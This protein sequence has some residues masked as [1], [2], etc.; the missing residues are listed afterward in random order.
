MYDVEGKKKLYRLRYY[1]M[2]K[3][4]NNFEETERAK[5]SFM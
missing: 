3:K 1:R 5:K 2:K 4:S